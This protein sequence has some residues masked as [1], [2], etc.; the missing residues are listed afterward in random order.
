M[1]LTRTA[2]LLLQMSKAI[3]LPTDLEDKRR[4]EI[5]KGVRASLRWRLRRI[6]TT[7]PGLSC[8]L[9][10]HGSP[11]SFH[12]GPDARILLLDLS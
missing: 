4:P 8:G 2:R 3:T 6:Q 10:A 11:N 7:P 9:L 5:F 12:G 1:I